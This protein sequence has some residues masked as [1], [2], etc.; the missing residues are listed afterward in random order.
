MLF[1]SHSPN[2]PSLARKRIP[3]DGQQNLVTRTQLACREQDAAQAR[4]IPR[5]GRMDLIAHEQ[6]ITDQPKGIVSLYSVIKVKYVLSSD[7]L[8]IMIQIPCRNIMHLL[9]LRISRS[10]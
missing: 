10:S 8:S 5:F 7:K 1:E 2:R 6:K 9:L 3:T 4:R